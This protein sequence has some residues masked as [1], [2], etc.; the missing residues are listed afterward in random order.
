ML[1]MVGGHRYGGRNPWS[2]A[3]G[4]NAVV[5]TRARSPLLLGITLL[6]SIAFAGVAPAETAPPPGGAI[7]TEEG[8]VV[9]DGVQIPS[10]R[11]GDVTPDTPYEWDGTLAPGANQTYDE[12]S[13]SPCNQVPSATGQCDVTLLNVN[14]TPAFWTSLGGG[15]QISLSDF[16]VPTSDFDM[17]VYKSDADGNLGPL[18]GSSAGLPGEDES[19][20]I[21][22]A[23]GY[24][25]I[26]VVYFAV[27]PASS[28]AGIAEFATR[29]KI[30]F[31]VDTPPGLQETLA[32][33]PAQ[34][35]K[36]HSEMHVA[37]NP[38]NENMLVAGSK[39]YNK[40]RDSLPE[41]EFKVGTYVS[42]DGGGSWTSLGQV[43]TC[44]QTEAPPD[45]WPENTCYPA[46]DPA[47]GG[48]GPEDADD[49]AVDADADPVDDRGE[50]DYGEEYIVSDPWVQFDDEGNAYLMVLDS[51][52]YDDTLGWGMSLHRWESVSPADVTSGNTWS[53]RIIINAYDGGG[54]DE[55]YLDDKNTFAVNNAGPD[56]DGQIG[57]MVACWGQN[58]STLIK[59]QTV[60]ERSTDGGKTW[61]DDPQVIST[62]DQQLVI[63]VNVQAD[64]VDPETF[65]AIWHHYTPTLGGLPAEMW[66]AKTTDGGESWSEPVLADSFTGVPT[67]YPNQAFRNLSIPMMG[68]GPAPAEG[69]APPLYVVYSEYLDAPDPDTDEDGLSADVVMIKS[70]DGGETWSDPTLVNQDEGNAD[71]FQPNIAMTE[72][73]QLNVVYFDRRL[74]TRPATATPPTDTD[75]YFTDVW[76]NRS[77]DG[78]ETW[79]ERRITHDSTDPELN[80][81]VS[82]SGL[83]F[84]DYQGLVAD[85]CAAIP[86][87][88]DT[89]L[90]NDTEL[91]PGPVRDPDFDE[92]IRALPADARANLK[93]QQALSWRVPNI[94][95][96]GGTN[97]TLPKTCLPT[98]DQPKEDT[99]EVPCP[100]N[101]V[102][103][104]VVG[105]RGKDTLVGTSGRDIL[106][107]G[108]K[109]DTLRGLGG[110]D[111]LIAGTGDDALRGG[112]GNDQMRAGPGNDALAGGGGTDNLRGGGGDDA[113]NGGAKKDRC[114]GGGGT[115]TTR[116]C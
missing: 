52:P 37:Q 82:G 112:G 27:A 33:N 32:S 79:T 55:G 74:D 69:E 70:E 20:S 60:C 103:N 42:F 87:V 48:T 51:P 50:T 39:F 58:L 83:F 77:N 64:T 114:V 5:Q 88:N 22:E 68:V 23:T 16:T 89:H 31:D 101:L 25:L 6:V 15:V 113:L 41:Y 3:Q 80:A 96:F 53:N 86:F 40:D 43:N 36:S 99:L 104:L 24:Y 81:P 21:K 75:N 44:P 116:A 59:Q 76:L 14:V 90:A 4:G 29:Y 108:R 105:T 62:P 8:P 57:I 98:S 11:Q 97:A 110:N 109:N 72:S 26:V 19:T 78:G 84:G 7:I 67:Q 73:G 45:S 95:S 10:A 2:T 115:D 91:D 13:A 65:Y 12:A 92:D 85:E 38:V 30:P 93:Y 28:Y 102:G 17:Y 111:L 100:R 35:W 94:A 34:G 106:C 47:V 1:G 49:P 56:G 71:Q 46:D 107:G 61:P 54:G 66:F 63:G 9:P 18:V